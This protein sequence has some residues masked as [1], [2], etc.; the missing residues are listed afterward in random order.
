MCLIGKNQNRGNGGDYSEEMNYLGVESIF[1]T[2]VLKHKDK[3]W[4]SGNDEAD[5]THFVP[6]Q[7]G[8]ETCTKT[9]K[10]IC[11]TDFRTS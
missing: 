7:A 10:N 9:P 1:R 4:A 3:K 5:E 6:K 11:D 2:D 8:L